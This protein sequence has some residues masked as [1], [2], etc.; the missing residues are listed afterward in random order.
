M[1]RTR[2][3][4]AIFLAI[5]LLHGTTA[6]ACGPFTLEAVF[7]YTVHPAYPLE[8]F[9]GG[10][11]GVVQ[12]SYARS[13]LYTAYRY[14]SG[15]SF[16]PSEQKALVSLWRERLDFHSE[17]GDSDWTKVWLTARQKV[18]GAPG[19]ETIDVYRAREKPN[20]YESYVNCNKDAFETAAAT[21]NQRIAKY[22]AGSPEMQNW[23]QAQDQV[24][25]NCSTGKSIP[26][27]A[28]QTV[29]A[30]LRADRAYQIAAATFYS[31]DFDEARKQFETIAADNTSPW[32][33]TAQYLVA[34]ALIRKA[35][36]GAPETTQE[37]LT[38]AESQLAK[39]LAD[40]KLSDLH[41]SATRLLNLLRL[42]LRPNERRHE[43]AQMLMA[44]NQND[45]LKQDLWDY[46]TF[47]STSYLEG[48]EKTSREPLKGDD[49]IRLDR[50]IS[51]QNTPPHSIIR[52]NAGKQRARS[53][54]L[55]PLSAT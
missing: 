16:T 46:T 48:D 21:L 31:A 20:E 32:Q 23:V 15:L 22:G 19:P 3:L 2:R 54:G 18:T 17:D 39:V 34:R 45:N 14:L 26:D 27:A 53:R 44:K 13:Y 10:R 41:A 11:I 47:C 35:S 30:L 9:A 5:I 7:V 1:I 51:N 29:D 6:L 28:P 42:R 50:H 37:A 40:R 38:A 25:A 24:F 4:I 43:L 36:L 52:S 49:L 12:P 33:R 8:R 55:S